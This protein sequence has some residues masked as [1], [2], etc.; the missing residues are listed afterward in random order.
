MKQ[1][2]SLVLALT[3]VT[4]TVGFSQS[5]SEQIVGEGYH[6]Y[7][8]G[9]CREIAIVIM[10][11]CGRLIPVQVIRVE[12]ERPDATWAEVDRSNYVKDQMIDGYTPQPDS[13]VCVLREGEPA[14]FPFEDP[15]SN[16]LGIPPMFEPAPTF[17]PNPGFGG[18][19][20]PLMQ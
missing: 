8:E 10:D 13:D 12:C 15:F 7:E 2:F 17:E 6:R 19:N 20:P 16:D 18:F 11:D 1:L 9:R 5:G 3:L 14:P 4:P